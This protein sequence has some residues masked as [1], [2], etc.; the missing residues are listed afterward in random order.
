MV[1]PKNYSSY[2]LFKIDLQRPKNTGYG[3]QVASL[4]NYENVLKQVAF[5]QGKWFNNVLLSI[6]R[7]SDGKP[8][9]KVILGP[10]PDLASAQNYQKNARKKGVKGFVTN[11]E[12]IA[13]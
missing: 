10:F 4:S 5:L 8:K 9:Y 6:E 1:V 3:V 2:G 11:L 7:G 13:Y 12:D